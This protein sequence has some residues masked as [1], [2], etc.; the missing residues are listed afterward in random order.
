M[1]TIRCM[2][3]LFG[4]LFAT[5][6]VPYFAHAQQ[7]APQPTPLEIKIDPAAFDPYV[8]QYEDVVN[9]GGTIFS[10]FREGDKFFLQVTNQDRIEIFPSASNTFFMKEPR[11]GAAEFLRDPNGRVT[12]MIWRQGGSEFRTK[13]I[14]N[15]P[16]KDTRVTFNRKEMMIPMRD[17]VKLFTVIL[18][19]ETQTENLPIYMERTPYGVSGWNSDRLNGSKTELVQDGYIFVFQDIRGRTDSEGVF[20]MLRPPRD[21]RDPGSVDESTDTYDTIEYLLKNVPK[22]NGRVGIAGVSYPGWLAAVALLDP[23]PA[24]KASSPQAPVTDLWMGDD[25]S[26]NGAFRQTYAHHWA[27]PLEMAKKGGNVEI[28]DTDMYNYYLNTVKLPTLSAELAKK[29]HSWKAFLEHPDWDFY[30]QAKATNLY[31]TDTSVPTLVVGGWWDQEDLF[32]P[33]A[34]YKGLEKTDKDDQVNLVMGPW[35]HGGWGGRGRRLGAID[36]GSDTGRYF[37]AE[38]LAPFFAYHLK[39]KGSLKLPEASIFRSGSNVWKAYDEWTPT[40]GLQKGALYFNA[41]GKLSFSKPAGSGEA[42][43]SYKS[44]PADPVPYRKR[45]IA[46]TYGQGSTWSAWLVD[47][48]RFL[49]DRRDVLSWRSDVLTEDVTITGDIVAK[50]F[51]STTGS[52]SDWVVKLIDVY[53]AEYPTDPKMSSY[54]LMVASE[55]FRGRYRESFE[56]PEAITPDRVAEYTVDMR[57]NDYTFKKGHRIMVQVQSTWFP[58][59]NR[60]PQKFVPNIL[61]ATDADYQAATQKIHRSSKYPSHISVSLAR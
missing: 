34:L 13:K 40:R 24:L 26:H 48:Q 30:W 10:F 12:G 9:L 25:F 3:F 39:G 2:V 47:D 46:V 8:G 52:D 21:K 15:Q 7:P 32:G 5:T 1:S 6:F 22:N 55:I 17:G 4:V 45:P 20:E 51:A 36:F 42:F 50:L 33:L 53:P 16:A 11:G 29:S 60:N 59:Y 38:I 56:K 44:D 54:E 57:G 35:N 18:T 58:L 49:R 23:H 37:R 43:D 27:V 14:A 28:S 61:L 41:D 31:V 19:P